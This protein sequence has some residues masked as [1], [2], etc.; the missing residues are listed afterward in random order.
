MN[1]RSKWIEIGL[2]LLTCIALF[3]GHYLVFSIY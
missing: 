1:K 2:F 3:V